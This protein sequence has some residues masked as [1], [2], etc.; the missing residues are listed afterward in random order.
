MSASALFD[1]DGTL[2]DTNYHH[3]LAWARA[4][5]HYEI[6]PPLWR[7]HRAIGMGG[8]HLVAAVAGDQAE[9]DHGDKLRDRWSVEYAPLLEE[10]R[11]FA[12]AADLLRAVRSRG[13]TVVLAS[14]A[15]SEHLDRYVDLLGAA[16]L[17]DEATTSDDVG[18][19]KPSPDLVQVALRKAGGGKAVMIGDSRWDVE[20]AGT[21][22]VPTIAVQTGGYSADELRQ[23]GAVAVYESLTDLIADLDGTLLA[24]GRD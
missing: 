5:A 22:D 9:A 10:V 11:P 12:G 19:T 16:D 17:I 15:P 3:T 1:V 4:F 18:S 14:S 24:N 8:D 7:I 20:A 21:L 2:V 13:F 6:H 23:A